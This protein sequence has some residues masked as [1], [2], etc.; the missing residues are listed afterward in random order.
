MK[1]LSRVRLFATPWT[2]AYQAPL[3]MEFS[4]Q[5]YWSGLPFPS[6]KPGKG[7]CKSLS[8]FHC[9]ELLGG[10]QNNCEQKPKSGARP[11]PQV[12][13]ANSSLAC[14]LIFAGPLNRLET[15]RNYMDS[16]LQIYRWTYK[17]RDPPSLH[18]PPHQKPCSRLN[19]PML[20]ESNPPRDSTDLFL[21]PEAKAT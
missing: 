11:N 8:P 18:E 10:F 4:R 7:P 6:P 12:D 21:T 5:E 16:L 20:L 13:A 19:P 1:S 15:L 14:D 9:S 3:S 2:V 17:F